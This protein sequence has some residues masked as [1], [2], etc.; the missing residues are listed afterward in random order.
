M[1][2]SFKLWEDRLSQQETLSRG[3]IRQ[4][5]NA[6]VSGANGFRIGGARTNLTHEECAVLM[7]LFYARCG[8]IDGGGFKLTQ[9]HT[10]FGLYWLRDKKARAEECG[11]TETMLDTFRGFRLVDY[12]IVSVSDYGYYAAIAPTYRVLYEGGQ[13]DYSWSPWQTKAYA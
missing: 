5:C 7:D 10:D 9:E 1:S 3:Q 8:E 4:W 12:V 6:I 11:V 13:V 2:S